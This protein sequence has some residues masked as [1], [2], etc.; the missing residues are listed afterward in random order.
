MFY[1]KVYQKN[2]QSLIRKELWNNKQFGR[3]H[4]TINKYFLQKKKEKMNKLL[5]K[6]TGIESNVKCSTT[7][8][9]PLIITFT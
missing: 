5:K 2:L 4:S 8:R 3:R 7:A 6:K 9:V 1:S